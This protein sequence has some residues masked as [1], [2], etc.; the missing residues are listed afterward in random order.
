M[1]LSGAGLHGGDLE[2][3]EERKLESRIQN[4][5]CTIVFLRKKTTSATARKDPRDITTLKVRDNRI[6]KTLK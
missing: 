5:S 2:W 6:R 3:D 1:P 4:R